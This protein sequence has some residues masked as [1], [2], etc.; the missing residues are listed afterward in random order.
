M[1]KVSFHVENYS[2]DLTELRNKNRLLF[3]YNGGSHLALF[4]SK[5]EQQMKAGRVRGLK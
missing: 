4:H 1:V 2:T 3:D 5:L